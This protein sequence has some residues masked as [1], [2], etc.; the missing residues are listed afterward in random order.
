MMTPN[1]GAKGR[2]WKVVERWPRNTSYLPLDDE[3]YKKSLHKNET[4]W[5]PWR[6]ELRE[7]GTSA[8]LKVT[9]NGSGCRSHRVHGQREA[10]GQPEVRGLAIYRQAVH[11]SPHRQILKSS[12]PPPSK[13]DC[14]F[15]G[16][17]DS[18]LYFSSFC[19]EKHG[20]RCLEQQRL[21]M[22]PCA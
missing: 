3:D 4:T 10:R 21:S 19:V 13:S 1:Y 9:K 20:Q 18:V 12:P 11:D 2:G 16:H 5:Q 6:G 15:C 7:V 8:S 17:R 22:K 14:H